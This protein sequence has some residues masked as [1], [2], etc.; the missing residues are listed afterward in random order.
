LLECPLDGL[1]LALIQNLDQVLNRSLRIIE[2]LSSLEQAVSLSGEVVVLF[3]RLLVDMLVLLERVID[4]LDLV[5]NLML[6][7]QVMSRQIR[8]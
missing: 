6:R 8:G 7:Q 3:E 5:G 4:L 2:F 1:I